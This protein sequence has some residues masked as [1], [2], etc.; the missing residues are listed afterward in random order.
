MKISRKGVKEIAMKKE[1]GENRRK[2]RDVYS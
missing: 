1:T 2:R